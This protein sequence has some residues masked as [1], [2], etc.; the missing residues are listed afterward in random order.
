MEVQWTP[1]QKSSKYPNIS[2]AKREGF[3]EADTGYVFSDPANS[4]S[5][6]WVPGLRHPYSKHKFSAQKEGVW[7]L[8]AGYIEKPGWFFSTIIEWAPGTIHPDQ[9]CLRTDYEEGKWKPIEGYQLQKQTDGRLR[10][11][12]NEVKTDWGQ[13]ATDVVVALI[14]NSLS[15][16]SA[17][18]GFVASTIGRPLAKEVRNAGIEAAV[19]ELSAPKPGQCA[20]VVLAERWSSVN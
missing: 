13:V 10:I 4:L 9:P 5:V 6:E 18:D 15:K 20:G 1:A 19:K 12:Q 7:L 17:D 2:A 11:V 14:A 8:E 3:W 16:P